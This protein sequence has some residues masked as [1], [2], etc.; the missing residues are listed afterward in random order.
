M[1][2]NTWRCRVHVLFAEGTGLAYGVLASVARHHSEVHP[3]QVQTQ[4]EEFMAT[5]ILNSK[6]FA[7]F[8]G[9]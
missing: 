5:R 4:V 9:I 6:G 8:R 2:P 3:R 1:A 7:L